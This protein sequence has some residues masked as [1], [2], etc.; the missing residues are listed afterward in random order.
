[1]LSEL[2]DKDLKDYSQRLFAAALTAA[3]AWP[4]AI[5]NMTPVVIPTWL[6]LSSTSRRGGAH[7]STSASG[8][9]DVREARNVPGRPRDEE[10]PEVSA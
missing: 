6:A 7:E 9:H 3:N 10:T 5:E 1:M 2:I 8:G 4:P